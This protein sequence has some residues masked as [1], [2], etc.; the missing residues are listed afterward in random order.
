M[1]L[2]LIFALIQYSY[3]R[4][5]DPSIFW[6][7]LRFKE[8]SIESF[9]S[10]TILLKCLDNPNVD[11]S[12]ILDDAIIDYELCYLKS[13]S[14]DNKFIYSVSINTIKILYLKLN[15]LK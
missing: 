10:K 4:F 1:Y 12:D 8:R 14:Y 11:P 15:S 5:S 6:S 13:A 2:D 3:A 7:K 9:V